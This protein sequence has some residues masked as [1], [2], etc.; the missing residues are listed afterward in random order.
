MRRV[1]AADPA[2]EATP[3]SVSE[4]LTPELLRAAAQRLRYVAFINA[5]VASLLFA[6]DLIS[7]FAT[8]TQQ[9]RTIAA[10]A[11]ALGALTSLAF[12]WLCYRLEPSTLLDAAVAFE[13]LQGFLISVQYHASPLVLQQTSRAWPAVGVWILIFTFLIPNTRRKMVFGIV[14]TASMDPL[15]LLV[16]L[17]AGAPAPPLAAFLRSLMPATLVVIVAILISRILYDLNVTMKRARELGSYLLVRPLG[18]GGMGEVWQAE[19]RRLA[20]AAAI[21]LIR[22]DALGRAGADE[23]IKRFEREARAT[24]ALRSPHTVEVYDFGT[25]E[26]GAF[27]YVMELLTGLDA[28]TLVSRHG[29]LPPERAVY[30]LLQCC[31]SLEEAHA[32]QFVHRDIKPA[33]IYVCR[34][35]M[36]YDFVK[37]L[38]FGLV[39]S[40]GFAEEAALTASGVV[41]GSPEYMAPEIARG[42]RDFDERVDLY[43][44]GCVAY[45]LVTGKPVFT[46]T[47]PLDLLIEH[48]KTSPT[49]PSQ[50][51]SQP[52]PPKLEEIILSCL[53]KDPANRPQTAQELAERLEA[54]RLTPWTSERAREWWRGVS[55]TP[56]EPGEAETLSRVV[57]PARQ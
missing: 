13:I 38:D 57:A 25:T 14:A 28:D 44:L 31:E 17:W 24:A 27:Y 23:L 40:V 49:P 47:T 34:Y 45:W 52:I 36:A 32:R 21:K 5:F 1:T 19:H 50:K 4:V 10:V 20:R 54:L 7:P 41:A 48:V 2:P 35:G 26:D 43:S 6:V 42:E 30:L 56:E 37:V 39:K 22:P 9:G 16:H 53:Q 18:R 55:L 51:A 29:P 8:V 3:S 33:N 12:A 11:L 46:G 15:G